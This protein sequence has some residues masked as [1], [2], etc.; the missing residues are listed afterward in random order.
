[1]LIYRVSRAFQIPAIK[2]LTVRI[3]SYLGVIASSEGKAGN[4]QKVTRWP[5]AVLSRSM[6]RR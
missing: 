1:M 5:I 4:G 3:N 2:L 6:F